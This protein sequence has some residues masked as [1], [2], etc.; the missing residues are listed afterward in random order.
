MVLRLK[1]NLLIDILNPHQIFMK[2][3]KSLLDLK[4]LMSIE[5]KENFKFPKEILDLYNDII[6]VEN[7]FI[8]GIPLRIIEKY[9]FMKAEKLNSFVNI[10]YNNFQIN[11]RISELYVILE[12][13]Y[14]KL[15]LIASLIGNYYNIEIKVN[16]ESNN[17]FI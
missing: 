8:N 3:S 9:Y 1:E 13:F 17:E 14:S 10:E 6:S 2:Y 16:T 4:T 15:Y 7:D 11:M 5:L 12:E